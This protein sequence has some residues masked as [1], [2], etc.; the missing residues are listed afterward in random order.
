M[1]HIIFILLTILLFCGSVYGNPAIDALEKEMK[2]LYTGY[3]FKS[4]EDL[5]RYDKLREIRD[6]LVRQDKN[7]EIVKEWFEHQ[8]LQAQQPCESMFRQECEGGV[9]I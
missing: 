5:K 7:N 1:K 9:K 8:E 2:S 4:I 3:T 6:S